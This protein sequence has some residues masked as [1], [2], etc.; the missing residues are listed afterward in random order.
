MRSKLDKLF[1]DPNFGVGAKDYDT[2]VMI[3]KN[4]ESLTYVILKFDGYYEVYLSLF[5][6]MRDHLVTTKSR[7][8]HF[9]K[10]KAMKEIEKI[11]DD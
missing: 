6:D 10:R 3:Y 5:D 1:D 9:A 2:G 4:K 11:L 7:V 8:L